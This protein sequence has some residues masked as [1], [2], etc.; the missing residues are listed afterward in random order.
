MTA[1]ARAA[2][3]F[4][5]GVTLTLLAYLAGKLDWNVFGRILGTIRLDTYG[6]AVLVLAGSYALN[7]VRWR[8]LLAGQGLAIP[9]RS[10]ISID[11]VAMFFNSFLPGST[12]GDAMRVYYA[13]RLLHGEMTRLVASVI[14]DRL[15]GLSIL[16]SFGYLAFL[17]RPGIAA[18]FELLQD[19][20]RWL[21]LVLGAA[22]A[23][24]GFALFAPRSSLPRFLGK[25]VDRAAR[26]PVVGRLMEFGANLRRRPWFLAF[27]AATTI[28]GQLVGF[29]AAYLIARSIGIAIDYP[30]TVLAMAIT[31][32]AISIPISVA[33]HGVREVVLVAIFAA[34]GVAS[35][36]PEIAVAFSVLFFAA[37]LAWSLVGGIWF[38]VRPRHPSWHP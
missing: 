9:L 7:T 16:L 34:M 37:Q 12:G 25:A 29:L 2:L 14:V 18:R 8:L 20:L 1:R 10:V 28:V 26:V 33:G 17:L 31:Q 5:I 22:L 21:P 15:I 13:S 30:E 38:T 3:L 24:S 32:T 4:K 19:A 27:A 11:L 35:G 23:G 6:A 36:R